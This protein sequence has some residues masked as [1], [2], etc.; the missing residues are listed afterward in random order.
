MEVNNT[1]NTQKPVTEKKIISEN[2]K[3]SARIGGVVGLAAGGA[4]QGLGY[5]LLRGANPGDKDTFVKKALEKCSDLLKSED[6]VKTAKETLESQFERLTKEFAK[7]KKD[8]IK[9]IPKNAVTIAIP[10]ILIGAGIGL[11]VD[12]AKKQKEKQIKQ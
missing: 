2:V 8:F 6:A 10:F 9:K 5:N 1:T 12:L 4:V 3:K 7:T 11:L